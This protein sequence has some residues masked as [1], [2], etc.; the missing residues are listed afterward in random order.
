MERNKEY[1][2]FSALDAPDH[3]LQALQQYFLQ[4]RYQYKFSLA[5]KHLDQLLERNEYAD[6]TKIFKIIT[7]TDLVTNKH[8]L[9]YRTTQGMRYLIKKGFAQSAQRDLRQQRR[10]ELINKTPDNRSPFLQLM[11][12][13]TPLDDSSDE[14]STKSPKSTQP[15][16]DQ[17]GQPNDNLTEKS[18]AQTPKTIEYETYSIGSDVV[19]EAED[20]QKGLDSALADL[21]DKDSTESPNTDNLTSVVQSVL[22]QEMQGIL[23]RF[24]QKEN[25]L[26]KST[27]KCN[28]LADI[29]QTKINQV[30]KYHSD[31]T[32]MNDH[33]TKRVNYLNRIL[34]EHEEKITK[35]HYDE[36]TIVTN[37]ATK[38]QNTVNRKIDNIQ[39]A[40]NSTRQIPNESTIIQD[41]MSNHDKIQRRLKRLKDGTKLMFQ[42]SDADYDLLTDR[43]HKLENTV[44][45]LQDHPNGR[46]LNFEDNHDSDS[47]SLLPTKVPSKRTPVTPNSFTQHSYPTPN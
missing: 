10:S 22:S 45:K 18:T 36:A 23:D 8:I 14:E 20:L 24:E 15:S 5:K 28:Q 38:V 37:I 40:L 44:Q 30:E 34:D 2:D 3:L 47:S 19:K 39:Q 1:D 29:L 11:K 33:M 27:D 32:E 7:G 4:K 35:L 43:V 41:V 21:Q 6:A 13:K 16:P 9:Q 46:K 26:Q 42:Q 17:K 25:D 31:F 12:N